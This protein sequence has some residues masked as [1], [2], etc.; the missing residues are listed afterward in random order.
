[1]KFVPA[2]PR[3]LKCAEVLKIA[4]ALG[5]NWKFG[6]PF[7]YRVTD[8]DESIPLCRA[9]P[10]GRPQPAGEGTHPSGEG[11]HPSGEGTHPSGEGTHPSGEGTHPSGEGTHP[12]LDGFPSLEGP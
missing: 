9:R 12:D 8:P 11:T 2:A 1:M 4:E 7:D 10:E 6:I 5:K 3:K